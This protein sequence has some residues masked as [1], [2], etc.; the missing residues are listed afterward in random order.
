MHIYTQVIYIYMIYVHTH[1]MCI[2]THKFD[3]FVC[4][5]VCI[6][7]RGI[8]IPAKLGEFILSFQYNPEFYHL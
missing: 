1:D 8:Q 3:L 6:P 5:C 7:Y 2:H 4:V